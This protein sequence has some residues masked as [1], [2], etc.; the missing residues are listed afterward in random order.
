MSDQKLISPYNINTVLGRKVVRRKKEKNKWILFDIT[1]I[2][3]ANIAPKIIAHNAENS[4]LDLG[5]ERVNP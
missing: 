2:L 4:Y 1:L 3:K 5:S